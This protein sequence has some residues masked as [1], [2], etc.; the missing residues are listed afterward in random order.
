MDYIKIDAEGSEYLILLGAQS[1][2][3]NY[4]PIIQVEI[5]GQ[6]LH[7]SGGSV[8]DC[9]QLMRQYSY[10]IINIPTWSEVNADHFLSCTHCHVFDPLLGKDLAYEG[11]GQILFIPVERK[12]LLLSITKRHCKVCGE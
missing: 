5:H 10:Q 6:L 8:D 2:I 9:F 1:I 11:Y 7:E 3:K 12:E 4:R